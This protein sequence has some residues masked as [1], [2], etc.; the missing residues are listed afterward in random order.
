MGGWYQK[1]TGDIYSTAKPLAVF[2]SRI[3]FCLNLHN[4]AVKAL[5]FPPKT[6]EEKDSDEY[7]RESQICYVPGD[8]LSRTDR[9]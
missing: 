2:S 1:D 8:G 3:A 7:W 6:Q 9:R 5:R 4:D